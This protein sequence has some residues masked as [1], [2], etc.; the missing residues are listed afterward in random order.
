MFLMATNANIQIALQELP[1]S[2]PIGTSAESAD[3]G[4]DQRISDLGAISQLIVSSRTLPLEERAT[5][6]MI[7]KIVDAIGRARGTTRAKGMQF[8]KHEVA[9]E[10]NRENLGSPREFLGRPSGGYRIREDARERAQARNTEVMNPGYKIVEERRDSGRPTLPRVPPGPH[11][12]VRPPSYRGTTNHVWNR[13]RAKI[14]AAKAPSLRYKPAK[15]KPAV[16]KPKGSVRLTPEQQN[17]YRNIYRNI[18][19]MENNP[20]GSHPMGRFQNPFTLSQDEAAVAS[21]AE[22]A[23][24]RDESAAAPV[25]T[26]ERDTF[27]PDHSVSLMAGL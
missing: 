3:D 25:Q 10:S 11:P 23:R 17:Y 13:L 21:P 12:G 9:R 14:R 18:N 1:L 27:R 26:A 20:A 6:K 8:I 15:P 22:P 24:A 19:R 5:D 4:F 7:E 2:G 16:D